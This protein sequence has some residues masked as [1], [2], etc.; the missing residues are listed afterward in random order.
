MASDTQK[1]DEI[2]VAAPSRRT[3][4]TMTAGS[5]AAFVASPGSSAQRKRPPNIIFIMADDLGFADLSCYGSAYRTPMIDRL[6]GEGLKMTQAYANSA[7]CSATRVGLIT[8]RYQYRFPVGL[9]EPLDH[10]D[11]LG[12]EPDVPT[13]PMMLRKLGYSTSLVG[14][15]HMGS[16]PEHGPMRSGYDRFYGMLGGWADYYPHP[17]RKIE[18]VLLDGYTPVKDYG[19]VTDELGKRAIKE[20]TDAAAADEPL[21]LS[22]HFTAPHWPWIGPDDRAISDK[23][24]DPHFDEGGS[25]AKLQE[26]LTSLDRNVGAIVDT[27]DRLGLTDTIVIFT[28]D[29]GGSHYANTWPLSGMKGEL[30]EGGLRVPVLIRWPGHIKKGSISDQVTI[31]MDWVPTLLSAAGGPSL[32]ESETDGL[33]ILPNLSEGA[34]LQ[35]RSLYWRFKSNEQSALRDGD[36]KYLNLG[37]T[38]W[39]FDLSKDQRERADMRK[40]EPIIFAQLKAKYQAWDAT[41][42]PYP[43]GSFS[44]PTIGKTPDRYKR[45]VPNVSPPGK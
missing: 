32:S 44:M 26:L 7:V 2:D 35:P 45:V 40:V 6:A 10:I 5:V 22:V 4:L 11:G 25:V 19:Y 28:S 42:L 27:I 37:N 15:W 21:Y 38:E 14:K 9:W 31:S 43:S 1:S 29:N 30:L 36:W 13:L 18:N 41:M 24:D 34:P 23:I 12:L 3:I 33:N 16:P 17:G 39:L 20:I 8:G